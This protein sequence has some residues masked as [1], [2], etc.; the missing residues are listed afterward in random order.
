LIDLSIAHFISGNSRKA[1]SRS[2]RVA[3]SAQNSIAHH[4]LGKTYFMMG[5]LKKPPVNFRKHCGCP[6]TITTLNTRLVFVI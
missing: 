3:A 2:T 1:S 5:D 6:P 4:L